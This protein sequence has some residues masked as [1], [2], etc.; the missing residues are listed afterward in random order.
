MVRCK[1]CTAAKTRAVARRVRRYRM[2]K[3]ESAK[4]NSFS[5][6]ALRGKRTGLGGETF[7]HMLDMF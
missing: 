6:K 5:M 7:E 1:P 3:D 2:L 4:G